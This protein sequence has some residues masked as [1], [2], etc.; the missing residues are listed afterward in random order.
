[1]R[2]VFL[3][4]PVVGPGTWRAVAEVTGDL[5]HDAHVADLRGVVGDE[6]PDVHEALRAVSAAMGASGG[7]SGSVIVVPHSGA[8]LLVPWIIEG[9]EVRTTAT[10][11]VDAGLPDRGASSVVVA[12]SALRDQLG[13]LVDEDGMLPP[14]FGWW[15]P[16]A[17]DALVPDPQRRRALEEEM[18]RIPIGYLE[19]SVPVPTGWPQAPGAFL[20]FGDEAYASEARRARG[21]GWPVSVLEGAGHLHMVVDPEKVAREVIALAGSALL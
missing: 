9:L 19:G 7:G 21:W 15:D 14:W 17:L 13:A 4:S 2:F 8:G 18:P 1:M 16:G 6:G 3:A 10:V 11:F 20:A 12:G 5:G